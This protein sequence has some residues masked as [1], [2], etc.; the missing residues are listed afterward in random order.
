[1]IFADDGDF[2]GTLSFGFSYF[3]SKHIFLS[4]KT[5][6]FKNIEVVNK[7]N[8]FMDAVTEMGRFR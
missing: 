2:K 5:D 4:H 3:K 1:M 8:K 6:V 7:K